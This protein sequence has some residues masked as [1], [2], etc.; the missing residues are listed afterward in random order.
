MSKVISNTKLTPTLSLAECTDGF[1]LWDDN[2]KQNLS[3]KAKTAQDALVEALD[4]A[5]ERC[6]RF[7][8][9]HAELS[10][11]VEAFVSQFRDDDEE[12]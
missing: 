11:K 4:I 6:A 9:A 10:Q 1:W 12:G 2:G 3:M 7:E 8:K 5:L